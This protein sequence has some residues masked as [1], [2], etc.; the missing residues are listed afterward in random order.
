M[1]PA[2]PAAA[3]SPKTGIFR[4]SSA[5]ISLAKPSDEPSLPKPPTY[6]NHLYHTNAMDTTGGAYPDSQMGA[7]A[8]I[9][10][11]ARELRRKYFS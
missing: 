11:T 4:G 7:I 3:I 9:R 6:K 8:Q 1:R 10:Q 2:Y 5:L